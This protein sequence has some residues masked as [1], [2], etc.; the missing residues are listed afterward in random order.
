MHILTRNHVN[1]YVLTKIS[2][3]FFLFI[4]VK[5]LSQGEILEMIE[6][7]LDNAILINWPCI[8]FDYIH[9]HFRI[10]SFGI[11]HNYTKWLFKQ[12]ALPYLPQL[13]TFAFSVLYIV[14]RM[15]VRPYIHFPNVII[16]YKSYTKTILDSK[17]QRNSYFCFLSIPF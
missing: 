11:L 8:S 5:L 15:L 2:F 12:R 9:F 1:R 17:Q 14:H 13:I 3:L 7:H 6:L 10:I 16:N 4:V